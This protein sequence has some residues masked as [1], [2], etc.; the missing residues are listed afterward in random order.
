MEVLSN[1]ALVVFSSE[2]LV[3]RD[4]ATGKSLCSTNAK[5]LQGLTEILFEGKPALALSYKSVWYQSKRYHYSL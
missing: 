2:E 4:M 5:Y 1:G 3:M